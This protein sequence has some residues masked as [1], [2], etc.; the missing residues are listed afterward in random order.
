MDAFM[1]LA[2]GLRH[3]IKSNPFPLYKGADPHTHYIDRSN[4]ELTKSAQAIKNIFGV[5]S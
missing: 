2:Y 1:A 3:A 4:P 5:R